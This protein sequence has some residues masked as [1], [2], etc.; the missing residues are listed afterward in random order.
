MTSGKTSG[1]N[2]YSLRHSTATKLIED[3]VNLKTVSERLGHKDVTIT[4][5]TYVHTTPGMEKEATEK[6]AK[7]LY[8]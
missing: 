6:I 7:A 2:L 1:C 5:T 8:G 3:G 4:L